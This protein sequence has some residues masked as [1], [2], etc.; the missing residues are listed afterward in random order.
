VTTQVT[1]YVT[2]TSVKTGDA[3]D[4]R[5]SNKDVKVTTVVAHP[6][7]ILLDA[8]DYRHVQYKRPYF[9]PAEYAKYCYCRKCKC[10][11]HHVETDHP[12]GLN[13]GPWTIYVRCH[14]E[15]D[16][17]RMD[18]AMVEA[19]LTE[20]IRP[21]MTAFFGKEPPAPLL[22]DEVRALVDK[23]EVSR[24]ALVLLGEPQ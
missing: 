1:G 2:V 5:I 23:G 18:E 24:A 9:H 3:D 22:P 19:I 12:H 21:V 13:R 6:R 7:T 8:Q 14:G 10:N 11:V 4:V 15:Q 16:S 20:Q 17:M